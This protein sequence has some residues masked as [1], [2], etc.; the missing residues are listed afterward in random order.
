MSVVVVVI[1]AS[2]AGYI[3]RVQIILCKGCFLE[4]EFFG[5]LIVFRHLSLDFAIIFNVILSNL[6]K[7]SLS[8]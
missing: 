2:C 8:F 1:C 7:L 6:S 3:W 5:K 4:N